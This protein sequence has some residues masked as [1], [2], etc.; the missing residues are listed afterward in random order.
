MMQWSGWGAASGW[1]W[2]LGAAALVIVALWLLSR[3]RPRASGGDEAAAILAGR[4]ARN[5]IDAAE[6]ARMRAVLG[7]PERSLRGRRLAIVGAAGLVVVVALGLFVSS[8]PSHPLGDISADGSLGPGVPGFVPGTAVAPRV[9]R[10]AATDQLRFAPAL[11][12]IAAGE[13][14]TFQIANVG[15]QVHEFKVGPA[16]DVAADTPGTPEIADIGMMGVKSLTYT[17]DGSGP[18]AFACHAPGHFE[19]GMIGSITIRP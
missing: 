10:I 1:A 15:M 13:T 17:F 19:A 8:G 4:F 6:Y 16:A 5:E 3:I 9:I 7:A 14:I 18:F 2:F 12:P 11:I